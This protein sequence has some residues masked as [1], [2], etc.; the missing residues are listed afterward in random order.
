MEFSLRAVR[1]EGN[2]D[3]DAIHALTNA[4]SGITCVNILGKE[5]DRMSR[6]YNRQPS[7]S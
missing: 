4:I 1:S 3:A 5:A 2:S 7:L 6:G